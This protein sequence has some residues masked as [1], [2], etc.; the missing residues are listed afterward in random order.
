MKPSFSPLNWS[1]NF[2]ADWRTNTLQLAASPSSGVPDAADSQTQPDALTAEALAPVVDEAKRRVLEAAG[3][4]SAAVLD[5]VSFEIVDLPGN[6][7]G[8]E[9]DA[10]TIFIDVD[11]AGQGWY[12]DTTPA[13]DQEFVET[14]SSDEL[15][16]SSSSPAAYRADLLTTV[17]H[18]LGHVLG[19]DHGDDAS[20]MGSSLCSSTRTDEASERDLLIGE[21]GAPTCMAFL[22]R[23]NSVAGS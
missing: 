22:T 19:Y 6:V 8:R 4:Q 18:E 23:T 16:A 9:Q 1:D 2:P 17:M 20:L 15:R 14:S 5:N 7:L 10:N 11:A 21:F 12:V 13:D 3:P